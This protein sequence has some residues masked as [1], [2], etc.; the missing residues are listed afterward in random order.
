LVQFFER[1][2]DAAEA[3]DNSV[4]RNKKTSSEHE[5][6]FNERIYFLTVTLVFFYAEQAQCGYG[7]I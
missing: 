6:Y 4:H 7:K 5:F 1:A 2:M 3:V